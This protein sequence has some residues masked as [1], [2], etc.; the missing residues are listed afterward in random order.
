MN[1]YRYILF[2]AAMLFFAEPLEA[3]DV[4]TQAV[5]GEVT[6]DPRSLDDG[7][8]VRL[9]GQWLFYDRIVEPQSIEKHHTTTRDIKVPWVRVPESGGSPNGQGTYRLE[10]YMSDSRNLGMMIPR[11]DASTRVYVNGQLKSK[12]GTLG[13]TRDDHRSVR[14]TQSLF[15]QS[16]PGKNTV[17]IQM[18]NFHGDLGG[19]RSAPR[20]GTTETIVKLESEGILKDGVVLGAI[21]IMGLYHFFLWYLRPSRR[22][23]LYYGA[24]CLVLGMR[25]LQ[26]GPGDIMRY[27]W[28][29]APLELSM[30]LTFIGFS[31]GLMFCTLLVSNLYEKY[32]PK[33]VKYVGVAQG[34]IWGPMIIFTP[35]QFYAIFDPWVQYFTLIFGVAVIYTIFRSLINRQKD[36]GLFLAGFV[37]FFATAINDILLSLGHIEGVS[38]T[39]GGLFVFLLFQS[40]ILS[41]RFNR[42]HDRAEEAE[43]NLATLNADLEQTVHQR[44]TQIKSIIEN[45]Q[46]AFL[47]VDET[48]RVEDGFT[49]SCYTMVGQQIAPGVPLTKAL[50]LND[51]QSAQMELAI[52]QVFHSVMPI[53]AA[54]AQIPGRVDIGQRRVKVEAK[55]IY[56][57]DEVSKKCLLF[58]LTDVTNLENAERDVQAKNKILN[59]LYHKDGFQAFLTDFSRQYKES[60]LALE[61]NK[62]LELRMILHTI[63]GNAASYGLDEL[64]QYIETCED[65]KSISIVQLRGVWRILEE[66]LKDHDILFGFSLE[67]AELTS[68]AVQKSKLMDV[69]EAIHLGDLS[70]AYERMS[71]LMDSVSKKKIA[72]YLPNFNEYLKQVSKTEDKVIQLK[73]SGD[74]QF[75]DESYAEVLSTLIHVIR[76]SVDHGIEKT[77]DRGGKPESGTISLDFR[78][79]TDRLY[80]EVADDGKGLDLGKI[81][82]KALRSGV[83]KEAD[84]SVMSIEDIQALIF[85]AGLSSR[86]GVASL[87]GRGMG[88]AAVKQA[89]EDL[90]GSIQISSQKGYGTTITLSLPFLERYQPTHS[91]SV[92]T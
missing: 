73:V 86:D 15:F 79:A 89:V 55:V 11:G 67:D 63:K 51:R 26:T 37:V 62:Q 52:D 5:K 38:L 59:I 28:K 48:G 16:F 31:W 14:R 72:N 50:R 69:Q 9:E 85:H 6:V 80:I 46:S 76:N 42:D 25:S 22:S 34:L 78:F 92:M 7:G 21:I 10:F 90:N 29:D 47:L 61:S 12:T 23:P 71:E 74:D 32:F 39:H 84:A 60:M 18:V 81:K 3:R 20:L 88:M 64:V 66:F 58:T 65:A 45:V 36:S 57:S 82:S 75:I 49:K 56:S 41:F 30:T 68:V 40:L 54:I 24:F 53:T 4:K 91:R 13:Q 17:T 77:S 43:A 19:F 33:W 27:I 44:T 1:S 2:L 83:I 8:T 70:I 35:Y 87:S